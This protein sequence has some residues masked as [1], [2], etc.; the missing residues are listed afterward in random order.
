MIVL[1][2]NVLSDSPAGLLRRPC[3]PGWIPPS[4]GRGRH[5]GDHPP[6]PRRALR[7]SRRRPIRSRGHQPRETRSSHHRRRRPDR[8]HLPRASVNPR[9][10]KHQG[11]RG[12]RTRAHRPV[13]HPRVMRDAFTPRLRSLRDHPGQWTSTFRVVDPSVHDLGISAGRG[14]LR[15]THCDQP[16]SRG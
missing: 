13:A 10:P 9:H 6:R 14:W 3:S 7:C 8:G 4:L 1:D 2:T 15:A 16:C 12:H 11:F 5:D